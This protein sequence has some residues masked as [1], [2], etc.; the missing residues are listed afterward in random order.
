M[1]KMQ[2]PFIWHDLMT[3]DVEAAKKFY[4]DVVGWTYQSQMPNYTVTLAGGLGMGGIMDTPPDMK[5]MPPVWTGYVYVPDVDAACKEVTKLGGKIYRE[6]WTIPDVG[7][8]AVIGDPTGSGLMIMQPLSTEKREE[9]KPGSVGTVGWNELHA[10]NLDVAW[11][12]YSKMFGW[13]KGQSMD[14]GEMGIYQVFQI[15]GQD[16]G[17]VMK[18]MDSMPMPMWAYYF[19]VDGIDKAVDRINKAGGKIAMGPHEVPG[20]FWIVNG[21]DPQGAFFSLLSTTK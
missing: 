19:N 8:I 21:I 18:K 17:G 4:A 12:F 1:S 5:H 2:N 16:V 14:M 9:P 15:G 11:D 6:A 7:R 20:G 10:G 13:T 3:K